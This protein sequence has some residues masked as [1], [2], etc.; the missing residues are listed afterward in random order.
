MTYLTSWDINVFLCFLSLGLPSD[1]VKGFV[2]MAKR[3]HE[4]Y[5]EDQT[6][7]WYCEV[8]P[9]FIYRE[10]Y[11]S[12]GFPGASKVWLHRVKIPCLSELKLAWRWRCPEIRRNLIY[13][14]IMFQNSDYVERLKHDFDPMNGRYRIDSEKDLPKKGRYHSSNGLWDVWSSWNNYHDI[15]NLKRHVNSVI[16]GGKDILKVDRKQYIANWYNNIHEGRYFLFFRENCLTG[17]GKRKS[18]DIKISE[19]VRRFGTIH[20]IGPYQQ[21][22]EDLLVLDGPGLG[23]SGPKIEHIDDLLLDQ[24]EDTDY[25]VEDCVESLIQQIENTHE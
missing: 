20:S 18:K 6:R 3:I 19:K 15:D 12:A 9:S 16:N 11:Q 4:R 10:S 2:E 24:F 1:L 22:A 14:M 17:Y 13:R 5:V 23:K 7:K 8:S 21:M 25:I